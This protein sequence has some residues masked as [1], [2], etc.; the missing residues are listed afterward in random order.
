N[1]KELVDALKSMKTEQDSLER[2]LVEERNAIARKY[3]EKIKVA[4]TKATLIGSGISKHE[5]TMLNDNYK[6]EV[7]KFDRERV[8][9][10]WDGLVAQQQEALSSFGVPTMFSANAAADREKQQRVIRVLE[11]LTNNA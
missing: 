7:A 10:A 11:G 8:I 6:K 2:R 3:E 1:R 4:A 9:P 5:A